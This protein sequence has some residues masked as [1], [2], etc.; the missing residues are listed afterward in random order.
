MTVHVATWSTLNI[1]G[2][3]ETGTCSISVRNLI[4]NGTGASLWVLQRSFVGDS[5]PGGTGRIENLA[6]TPWDVNSIT[7]MAEL[8]K[9]LSI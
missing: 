6:G 9:G 3:L 1:F 4:R 5:K 8:V 2:S 7:E